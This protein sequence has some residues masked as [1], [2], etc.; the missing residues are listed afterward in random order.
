MIPSTTNG[1]ATGAY[2]FPTNDV[3]ADYYG[4]DTSTDEYVQFKLVMPAEWDASAGFKAKFYWL[5]KSS[6]TTSHDV[7]WGIQATSHADGGTIDSA[8][9]T[10]Q[11]IHDSV[12]GTAFGRVHISSATPSVTVAGSPVD[13]A[14][15][16]V[17]FR[18]YRDVDGAGTAANDDLNEDAR[19]LGVMIQYQEVITHDAA[20]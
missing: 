16:F 1:A 11:V 8:W 14:D 6:T 2:E 19:L 13:H 5:P 7:T 18:V 17:F 20:W 4:F 3:V 15:E 10:P 9:G 12:L